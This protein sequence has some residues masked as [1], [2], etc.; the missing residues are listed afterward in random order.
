M[1]NTY[2]Q[3]EC[4]M[5]L[6]KILKMTHPDN[7]SSVSQYIPKGVDLYLSGLRNNANEAYEN[8]DLDTLKNI[9][10]ILNGEKELQTNFSNDT[11]KTDDCYYKSNVDLIV[12][13]NDYGLEVIDKRNKG[14][15]LWVL[16]TEEEIGDIIDEAVA[17]YDV[18]GKYSDGGRA[19]KYR[20][21]WWTSENK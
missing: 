11:E 20:P 7:Y 2:S 16:G 15:A 13:F 17:R 4:K 5:L 21:A 10:A 18:H 3:N 8:N 9:F 19:T 1:N 14:G 6:K 12:F